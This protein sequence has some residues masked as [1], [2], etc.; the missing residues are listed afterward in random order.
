[1]CIY[2]YIYTYYFAGPPR[3]SPGAAARPP[4]TGPAGR[5]PAR[6][7]RDSHKRVLVTECSAQLLLV[8]LRKKEN[9]V[10]YWRHSA[11]PPATLTARGGNRDLLSLLSPA[12]RPER[13]PR[14]RPPA[15]PSSL[16][17][18]AV[19]RADEPQAVTIGVREKNHPGERR[20]RSGAKTTSSTLP[21]ARRQLSY[22]SGMKGTD[23]C[24]PLETHGSRVWS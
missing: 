10:V 1:M 6:G 4:W 12:R 23:E 17:A 3:R 24:V 11:A 20:T 7:D 21:R 15:A 19:R 18:G 2:I 13:S 9:Y 16:E 8:T 22:V 14:L 5:W